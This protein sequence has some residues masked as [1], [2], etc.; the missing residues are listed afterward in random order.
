MIETNL[1]SFLFLR[2]NNME[3]KHQ[4]GELEQIMAL[5]LSA[6]IQMSIERIKSWYEYWDGKVYVSFSGGKDSTVLLHLVR[7]IYPDVEAVFCD[8]GLEYPEIRD[9]VKTF[10]NVQIIRPEKN[11]RKIIQEDG[12]PFPTKEYA[13]KI[14]YA[15]MGSNWAMKY[16]DE[17]N[18]DKDGR[19]SRYNIPKRYYKLLDSNFKI[20]DKCCEWMKKRP[21]K[22]FERKTKKRGYIGTLA[23]ESLARRQAWV[24]YGCNVVNKRNKHSTPIAFWTQNDIY[25][26]I[27]ENDLKIAPIYGDIIETGNTVNYLGT[28]YPEYRTTGLDRTG[29]VFCMFGITKEKHPNRFEKLKETHPNLYEYCMKSVAD[30]GLGLDDFLKFNNI[31]H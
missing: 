19:R 15:Q 4:P 23:S 26:Y 14:R 25:Q 2:R 5:P 7:S 1:V 17:N 8:T 27:I 16:F 24:R 29:C 28:E 18:Q 20:S 6:K 9:F 11:F 31:K 3:N 30:G 22:K 21:F 10:E 13:R 12:Y